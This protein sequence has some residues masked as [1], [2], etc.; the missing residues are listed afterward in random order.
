MAYVVGLDPGGVT[1][2]RNLGKAVLMLLTM[3]AT[4]LANTI[5]ITYSPSPVTREI[6]EQWIVDILLDG[7]IYP[8]TSENLGL[9]SSFLVGIQYDP[10]VISFNSAAFGE[11]ATGDD[12][13]AYGLPSET[14]AETRALGNGYNSVELEVTGTLYPLAVDFDNELFATLT[15]DAVGAGTSE[16]H[17]SGFGIGGNNYGDVYLWQSEAGQIT[18]T[19]DGPPNSVPD[20]SNTLTLLGLAVAGIRL[21]LSGVRVRPTE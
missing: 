20:G 12:W 7:E 13:K 14:Y 18:V 4:A 19:G 3:S 8:G 16:L 6:G 1:V 2:Y 17:R 9:L 10:A 5:T 21:V 11:W 15:F